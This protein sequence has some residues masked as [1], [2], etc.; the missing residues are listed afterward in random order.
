MSKF[1]NDSTFC[2]RINVGGKLLTNHLKEILSYRY[3]V[4]NRPLSKLTGIFNNIH[5]YYFANISIM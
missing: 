2:L 1:I 4:N 5:Y 3:N